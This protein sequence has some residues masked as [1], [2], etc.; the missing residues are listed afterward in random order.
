[1]GPALFFSA[2]SFMTALLSFWTHSS[3]S[4]ISGK[5]LHSSVVYFRFSAAQK[6]SEM[7]FRLKHITDLM[8]LGADLN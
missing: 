4:V 7:S 8:L 1:M 6:A 5:V 3:L 2:A